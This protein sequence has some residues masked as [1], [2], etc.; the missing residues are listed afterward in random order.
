M[1]VVTSGATY[2]LPLERTRPG[3]TG[4]V[5]S[6]TADRRLHSPRTAAAADIPE[7]V[8][9]AHAAPQRVR[10]RCVAMA[11]DGET[12][13]WEA[14]IG[15]EPK[16]SAPR[17]ASPRRIAAEMGPGPDGTCRLVDHLDYQPSP[18]G[19]CSATSIRQH[20]PPLARLID[21]CCH[22]VD[23]RPVDPE[24]LRD[25]ALR[26][27][28]TEAIR[29]AVGDPHV[30]PKVR[31]AAAALGTTDVDDVIAYYRPADPRPARPAPGR[32]RPGHPA[33]RR[34]ARQCRSPRPRRADRPCPS[35]RPIRSS[36]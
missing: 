13:R 4:G 20:L 32:G 1:V 23:L 3:H 22:A 36:C 27:Y 2:D 24:P 35:R 29:R 17:S 18:T 14:M 7:A 9:R 33:P 5:M 28:A 30:G 25:S 21:R 26:V 16:R 6:I 19:C 12:A 11:A 10:G 15:L 34:S 31:A 8:H